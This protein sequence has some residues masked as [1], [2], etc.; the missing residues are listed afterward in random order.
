VRKRAETAA[1]TALAA[2]ALVLAAPAGAQADNT[3]R[4]T[5]TGVVG[6]ITPGIQLT[7]G[8]GTYTLQSNP[9]TTLCSYN[10]GTVRNS[11]IRSTGSFTST[12]CGT[13]RWVGSST[14]IDYGND[15]SNEVSSATY[16]LDLAQWHGHW[17]FSTVNG[18]PEDASGPT[19]PTDGREIDGQVDLVPTAG[20]CTQPSGVTQLEF[21]GSLDLRWNSHTIT[22][23]FTGAV[24]TFTPG[25][26]LVGGSG[27]YHLA[28]SNPLTTQCRYDGAGPL[29]SRIVTEGTFTSDL[30]G[31]GR[32]IESATTIDY[33]NDGFPEVTG[34]DYEIVFTAG[35]GRWKF[36]NVNG[37]R[38]DPTD[39]PPE[40]SGGGEDIDGDLTVTP[41]EGSCTSPAGVTAFAASGTLSLRW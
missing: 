24:G 19:D 20:T 12:V 1:A 40:P 29:G 26:M 25:V 37:S 33:G 7:G 10:G 41:S 18:S 32:W 27:S 15:G 11:S 4:C 22:C 13:G 23:T 35:R 28:T 30:C 34:A 6:N 17:K 16:Q 38:E 36:F 14:Q 9:S 5:F 31:S 39:G 21:A 2:T 8:S 3:M